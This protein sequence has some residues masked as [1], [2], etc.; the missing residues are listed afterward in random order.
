MK[1]KFMQKIKWGIRGTGYI[2]NRFAQGLMEDKDSELKAVASRHLA[3]AKAFS[4][5]YQGDLVFDNFEKMLKEADI[6]VLYIATPNNYHFAEIMQAL[7]AGIPVLSEKPMVDDHEQFAEVIAKAKEK[8]LFLMEGMWTRFFPAMKQAAAWVKS[9]K[10][11][12]VINI[13]ADFSYAMDPIKDQPWKAGIIN[14]A[15]ALR[16]VGIYSLAFADL[17]FPQKPRKMNYSM[18]KGN[19]VDQRIHL[20]LDYGDAKVAFLSSAFTHH[21][22]ST[23]EIV[24]TNGL[25]QVGPE[26]WHPDTARIIRNLEVVE[27]F[28]QPYQSTGFQFEVAEVVHCLRQGLKE[29]SRYTWQDSERI[30]DIIETI[31]KDGGIFY[32]SD[33]NK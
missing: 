10:I 19:G 32:D 24:G 22:S 26:F 3:A 31:R 8:D 27:E 12:D 23:A 21:G 28:Y 14:N 29:S 9:G 25:I 33:I 7:D 5:K 6:D 13:K 4:N 17:F 16:D 15:G 20:F 30:A 1:E 18:I 11:G 2:A